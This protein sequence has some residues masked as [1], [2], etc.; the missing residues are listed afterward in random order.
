M[1][2]SQC[3]NMQKMGIQKY[4]VSFKECWNHV[5][6]ET[7]GVKAPENNLR[8]NELKPDSVMIPYK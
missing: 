6:S 2:I 7:E 4:K 3:C 1:I 5:L 8:I